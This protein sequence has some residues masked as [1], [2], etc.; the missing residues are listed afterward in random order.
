[1][2]TPND[3]SKAFNIAVDKIERGIVPSP[4]ELLAAN[5]CRSCTGMGYHRIEDEDGDSY[6]M[7]CKACGGT[8]RHE[9]E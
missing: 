5:L 1:M 6:D 3:N 7:T 8:G 9:N 2:K 4:A